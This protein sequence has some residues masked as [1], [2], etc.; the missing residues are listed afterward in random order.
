MPN[1][2]LVAQARRLRRQPTIAETKLW[3]RLRRRALMGVKFRRQAVIGP[4]V[5]DFAAFAERLVVEVDGG[6]HGRDEER[7][8]DRVRTAWLEREGWRV[9]RVRNEDVY[10]RMDAVLDF[11][12]AHLSGASRRGWRPPSTLLR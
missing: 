11:I 6:T 7:A 5:A 2:D 8:R 10:R 12:A 4:Y 3:A 9:I 1:D